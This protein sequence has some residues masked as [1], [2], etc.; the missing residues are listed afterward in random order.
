MDSSQS[1]TVR[2][3]PVAPFTMVNLFAGASRIGFRDFALGTVLAMAPGTLL[4]T[5]AADRAVA[6][7]RE[8]DLLHVGVAA[9][10]AGL[11]V[12]STIA[13]RRL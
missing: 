6:A 3:L 10:L 12:G 9:L 5:L 4:L 8:P 13:L 7:W 2:L 1:A 11:L